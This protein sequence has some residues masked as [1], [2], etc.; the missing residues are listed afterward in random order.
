MPSP[1]VQSILSM[2]APRLSAED[3]ADPAQLA[4]RVGALHRF[5]VTLSRDLA[6]LD[7]FPLVE[8]GQN[9]LGR[10][11]RKTLIS[12]TERQI[13][14][15]LFGAAL[16]TDDI[17]RHAQA[18]SKAARALRNPSPVARMIISIAQDS[19]KRTIAES[20]EQPPRKQAQSAPKGALSRMNRR[21]IKAWL[22]DTIAGSVAGAL[23][24][25]T[26]VGAVVIGAAVGGAVSTAI[27]A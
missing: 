5:T 8:A 13:L 1:A 11:E 17:Q 20:D 18:A 9:S 12:S 26:V 14:S 16:L 7:L 19:I 4:A 10:L 23:G 25:A 2:K 3:F 22:G 24:A 6:R 15:E 21:A 27:L